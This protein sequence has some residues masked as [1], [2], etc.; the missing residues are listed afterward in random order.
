MLHV[1]GSN[2]ERGISLVNGGGASRLMGLAG[3]RKFLDERRV[4]IIDETGVSAGAIKTM[5]SMAGLEDIG[6]L[7]KILLEAFPQPV[8]DIFSRLWELNPFNF[9]RFLIGDGMADFL[10]RLGVAPFSWPS[11]APIDLLPLMRAVW[12][13]LGLKKPRPGFRFIAVNSRGQPIAFE[14]DDFDGP[15]AVAGSCTIPFFFNPPQ[16]LVRGRA[17]KL[18][19]G[20]LFHPHPSLWSPTRAIVFQLLAL[21]M[22][23]NR[24]GDYEV[25]VGKAWFPPFAR[26]TGE[27]IDELVACGYRQAKKALEEPISKGLIPCR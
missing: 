22:Y 10:P 19:D 23:R 8:S 7:A 3:A 18:W 13:K 25:F 1:I 16:C 4:K 6:E 17:T 27:V 11:G 20:G 9:S 5:C 21:P 14:G 12:K 24:P 2:N 26:L 15:L